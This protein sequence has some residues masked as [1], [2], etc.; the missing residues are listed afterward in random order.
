MKIIF[1]CLVFLLISANYCYT[2]D[3]YNKDYPKDKL[4]SGYGLRRMQR[5]NWYLYKFN[6]VDKEI[7]LQQKNLTQTD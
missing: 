6:K 1:F 3:V 2:H 7:R 5:V 4:I